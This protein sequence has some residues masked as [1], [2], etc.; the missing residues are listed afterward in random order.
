MGVF[1]HKRPSCGITRIVPLPLARDEEVLAV[2]S[3]KHMHRFILGRYDTHDRKFSPAPMPP[4]VAYFRDSFHEVNAVAH[5]SRNLRSR[6][7]TS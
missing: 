3:G 1:A 4:R 7:T 6:N 2:H 5:T